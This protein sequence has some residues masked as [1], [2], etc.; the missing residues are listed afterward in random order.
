MKLLGIGFLIAMSVAFPVYPHADK[1]P[2]EVKAMLDGGL[3]R[4]VVDVREESEYCSE[5]LEPP[6]HIIGSI[7]MPWNSGYFQDH[8]CELPMDQ[9]IIIVCQSGYRSHLAACF[10][11]VAGY[12]EVFD[13][14]GGMSFWEWD[15]EGCDSGVEAG[16]WG[17]IKALYR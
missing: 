4:V 13:M 11:D 7:N 17:G 16:T 8:C 14:L 15:S 12:T 9:D 1:T 10:L 2:T 5:A 6:G 3:N